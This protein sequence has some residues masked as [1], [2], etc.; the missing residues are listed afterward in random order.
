MTALCAKA[1]ICIE[2]GL[3]FVDSRKWC[4]DLAALATL[5]R[6]VDLAG[7]PA[8]SQASAGA[9]TRGIGH[10]IS[11]H[12]GV[13]EEVTAQVK[14]QLERKEAFSVRDVLGWGGNTSYW[15]HCL[16]SWVR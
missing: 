10:S 15:F 4:S 2:V 8:S 7:T 13:S 3:H 14:V 9:G 6:G 12:R 11:L 5:G 16:F 1:N